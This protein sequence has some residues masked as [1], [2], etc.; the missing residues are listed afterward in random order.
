MISN[1]W[2]SL[3]LCSFQ[4]NKKN[5]LKRSTEIKDNIYLAYVVRQ[6]TCFSQLIFQKNCKQKD[7]KIT[8]HHL[9]KEIDF[10]QTGSKLF[11]KKKEGGYGPSHEKCQ[12][13]TI[14]VNFVQQ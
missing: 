2:S 8:K 1:I 10:V 7:L 13:R 9:K 5:F 4:I 6:I 14:T 3:L 11:D 12:K